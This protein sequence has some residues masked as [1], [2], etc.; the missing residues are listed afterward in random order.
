M[1]SDYDTHRILVI[2]DNPAIH[3][4]FRKIFGAAGAHEPA[5]ERA[6]AELFDDL[7]SPIA[8]ADRFEVDS[9]SQGKEGLE[10][11]RQAAA[12]RRPY[13]MAFVDVRMPP[14]WDGVETA[15]HIREEF[16]DQQIVLCTA[17][18]DYTWE[19]MT[20][21]LGRSDRL[22]ILDKPFDVAEVRQ[23]VAALAKR[24]QAE[25]AL[26]ESR[27]FLQRSFDAIPG[28]LMVIDCDRRVLMHN[29]R[30]SE[31]VPTSQQQ[32]QPRC[33]RCLHAE[34]KLCED[35]PV[36][37]ALNRG[38]VQ[39]FEHTTAADDRHWEVYASPIRD[40]SGE[41]TLVLGHVR[42]VTQHKQTEEELKKYTYALESAN[43]VLEEFCEAAETA[44][45]LK[46]EFLANMSHELRTPLHGILSFAAFGVN[47]ADTAS[48]ED[49]ARYFEKIESSGQMLLT[50][51]NDLLDLSK[52]ESGKTEF[53]FHRV[54]LSTVVLAVADEFQSTADGRQIT[55]ECIRPDLGREVIA[56]KRK[57]MQV[58]RNLLSNAIKFSPDGS[59]IE[60][61]IRPLERSVQVS[62]RDQ[63]IGIPE[64]EL[65]AVFDKF[66]QSSKTRTGAGG[67]GL[68][69]S[70]CQEIVTAHKGHIRANNRPEGG[71]VLTFEVPL[72]LH[73]VGPTY[74][75]QLVGAFAT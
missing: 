56:D 38:E 9:A 11:I 48:R 66:V 40:E 41:V 8:L 47:K 57:M 23:L 50:L 69:L 72:N 26:G 39:R 35:C 17:F 75:N 16:P 37:E 46:S 18:S 61:Q 12:Q 7:P 68:G 53:D 42:D 31:G 74:E 70:I 71:A 1:S 20:R 19:D 64:D 49:L 59:T 62:V 15:V 2:D 24:A 4:D 73:E 5:M 25:A 27:A 36:D 60:V 58:V 51:V 32:N 3:K 21:R 30:E 54:D 65:K 63:G 44:N 52:L 45:R 29:W 43:K 34:E 10:R 6:A 67:T 13:A 14:G 55:I 28:L 33:Y 22:F